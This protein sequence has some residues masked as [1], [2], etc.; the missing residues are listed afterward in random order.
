MFDDCTF[1]NS[2]LDVGCGRGET[3]SEIIKHCGKNFNL[4]IGVDGEKESLRI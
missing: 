3:I 4:N 1:S 2:L